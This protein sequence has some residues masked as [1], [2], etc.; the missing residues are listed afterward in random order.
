MIV[1]FLLTS[2]ALLAQKPILEGF[3][4]GKPENMGF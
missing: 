3:Y 2:H 1:R 4:I